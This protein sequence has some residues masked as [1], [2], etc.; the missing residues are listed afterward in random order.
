[1]SRISG[2]RSRLISIS[3]C[4]SRVCP[5]L[6]GEFEPDRPLGQ[7]LRKLPGDHPPDR[8][9]VLVRNSLG[10]STLPQRPDRSRGRLRRREFRG[11]LDPFHRFSEASSCLGRIFLAHTLDRPDRDTMSSAKPD[12]AASLGHRQP[13][14]KRDAESESTGDPE[15]V[16]RIS[17]FARADSPA[18]VCPGSRARRLHAHAIS[19]AIKSRSSAFK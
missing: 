4:F 11:K 2:R 16:L 5:E 15:S 6:C 1:M 12:R 7:H 13:D 17:S 19:A 9:I 8:D 14:K 18:R 3:C 10:A